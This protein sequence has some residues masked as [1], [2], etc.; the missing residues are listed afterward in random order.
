MFKGNSKYSV[1]IYLKS[2][3]IFDLE[4]NAQLNI[5]KIYFPNL[6]DKVNIQI[7]NQVLNHYSKNKNPLI[8]KLLTDLENDFNLD[9]AIKYLQYR[10]TNLKDSSSLLFFNLKYGEELGIIKFQEKLLL[11]DSMSLEFHIKKFGRID[12]PTE[13]KKRLDGIKSTKENFILKYGEDEGLLRYE[14]FCKNNSGN[15][16]KERF[17]NLYGEDWEERWNISYKNDIEKGTLEKKILK[18]GEELGTKLFNE[19]MDKI[20][21]GASSEGF[22]EKYGSNW[23]EI[24][25]KSK[26]NTSVD[27][28]VKRYGKIEGEKKYENHKIKMKY[29]TS[30]QYFVDKYG[31]EQGWVVYNELRAKQV[32]AFGYSKVSQELFNIVY[33]HVPGHVYFATL[34]SEYCVSGK[35]YCY[36]YDYV[37]VD[38]KKCIEFNG[39]IWHGNPKI[40]S[41][42]DCPNPFNKS[43]TAKEIWEYDLLKIH[44]LKT[45]RNIDTLEVWEMDY[46]NNKQSVITACINFL[47][48]GDK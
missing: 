18:F 40:Y 29:A 44:Q 43:K 24:L 41:E 14:R 34:N 10:K 27:A 48:N 23:K 46:I 12:G 30:L 1:F 22:K 19:H 7:L 42:S 33:E 13:Y 3:N 5:H 8:L 17:Q 11:T 6:Y 45:N 31:E 15:K 39:D 4:Y 38:R 25:R 20:H 47:L 35:D 21:F 16:T 9:R 28:F 32:S 36:F 2:K 37:D 26:D